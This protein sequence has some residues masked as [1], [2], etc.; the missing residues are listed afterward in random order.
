[1]IVSSDGLAIRHDVQMHVARNHEE[2]RSTKIP[3]HKYNNVAAVSAL[4]IPK[5]TTGTI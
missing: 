5:Q 2:H 1:M 3:H 4:N